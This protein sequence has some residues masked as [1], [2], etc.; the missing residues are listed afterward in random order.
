MY[1]LADGTRWAQKVPQDMIE[2][3]HESFL[4]RQDC[5]A[6][7]KSP[8]EDKEET[9]PLHKPQP[10]ILTQSALMENVAGL[11]AALKAPPQ[12]DLTEEGIEPNPGPADVVEPL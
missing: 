7:K 9:V 3:L 12:R 6:E 11:F 10:Q 5:V 1:E 4:S 8:R 2:G